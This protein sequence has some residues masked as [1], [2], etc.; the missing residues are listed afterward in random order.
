MIVEILNVLPLLKV[1]FPIDYKFIIGIA[2]YL[3]IQ[4]RALYKIETWS[5]QNIHYYDK[6]I[7][8][9]RISNFLEEINPNCI[10]SFLLLWLESLNEEEFLYYDITSVSSYCKSIHYVRRGYNRDSEDLEQINIALLVGQNTQ[11]SVYYRLL[12]VNITDLS[13]I[14]RTFKYL[15]LLSIKN[16]IYIL[17]RGF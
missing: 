17:V 2:T 13:S 9:P 8:G 1:I 6:Y 14:K 4:G 15:D 11:L 12:R 7:S 10:Q 5:L 16:P 3:L